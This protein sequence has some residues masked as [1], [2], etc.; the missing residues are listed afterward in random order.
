MEDAE[1]EHGGEVFVLPRERGH[2]RDTGWDDL[3]EEM[4][5]EQDGNQE[6]CTEEGSGQGSDV[7]EVYREA[8]FVTPRSKGRG[9]EATMEA[10]LVADM[11]EALR[12][13]EEIDSDNE[14]SFGLM[15]Q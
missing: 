7:E 15:R 6:Q 9:T 5:E 14:C 2:S 1:R 11:D 12:G 3:E 13:G 8:N 10:M 4:V